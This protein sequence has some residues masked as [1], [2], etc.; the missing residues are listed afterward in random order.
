MWNSEDAESPASVVRR[1]GYVTQYFGC[2]ILW[3]SKLQTEIALSTTESEYIALSAACRELIHLKQ[4][5]NEVQEAVGIPEVEVNS[6][7]KIFED[8]TACEELAKVP[9]NRPRT[10]HIAVKYHHFR[11]HVRKGTFRVDLQLVSTKDHYADQIYSQ[12]CCL[13]HYSRHC[14]K[15][16]W[17]GK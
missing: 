7:A 13:N 11:E 12:N 1:S 17:D 14:K 9:K 10:K 16:S 2:P 5:L 4:L 3:A 6:H 8:N 15:T